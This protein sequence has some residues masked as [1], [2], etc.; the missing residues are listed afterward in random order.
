MAC[1]KAFSS[2]LVH[3][4]RASH[5]MR[6]NLPS[7]IIWALLCFSFLSHAAESTLCEQKSIRLSR[8]QIW[9]GIIQVLSHFTHPLRIFLSRDLS[10]LSRI[11]CPPRDWNR[12]PERARMWKPLC[13]LFKEFRRLAATV[14]EN[15]ASFVSMP[16]NERSRHAA[17]ITETNYPGYLQFYLQIVKMQLTSAA[18]WFYSIKG[19]RNSIDKM[20]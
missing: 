2:F 17:G 1:S 18:P 5:C 16:D 7:S 13:G 10:L 14:F 3:F 15:K 20:I 6:L 9:L 4:P 12:R 11:S 8:L 19:I